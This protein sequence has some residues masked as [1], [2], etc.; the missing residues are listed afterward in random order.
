LKEEEEEKKRLEK[1]AEFE[2]KMEEKRAQL[3][4]AWG[5]AQARQ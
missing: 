3:R 5:Q 4:A 2:R 1:V